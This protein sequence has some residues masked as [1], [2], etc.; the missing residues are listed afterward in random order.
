MHKKKLQWHITR[1]PQAHTQTFEFCYECQALE[2]PTMLEYVEVQMDLEATS[3]EIKVALVSS[4]GT[5]S[6]LMAFKPEIGKSVYVQKLRL[7]SSHFWDEKPFGTWLLHVQDKHSASNIQVRHLS[8]KF[9][10]TIN[11]AIFKNRQDYGNVCSA[12]NRTKS[13]IATNSS[14]E[15]LAKERTEHKK[16][17]KYTGSNLTLAIILAIV[18]TIIIIAGEM[19]YRKVHLSER[20]RNEKTY[21]KSYL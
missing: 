1:P 5:T 16:E 18:V 7:L 10:G 20:L 12:N 4:G 19:Y 21:Y 6:I 17:N 2:C 8:L 13:E 11:P 9:Y 15:V 14:I 3:T